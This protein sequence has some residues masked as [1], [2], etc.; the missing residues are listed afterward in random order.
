VARIEVFDLG[1]I[2][3]TENPGSCSAS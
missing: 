2:P 1:E 3:D